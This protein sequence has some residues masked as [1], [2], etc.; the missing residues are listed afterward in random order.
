MT[1]VEYIRVNYNQGSQCVF[2]IPSK[3]PKTKSPFKEYAIDS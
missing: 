2:S 1:N 3:Y